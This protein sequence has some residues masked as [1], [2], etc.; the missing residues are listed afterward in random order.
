MSNKLYIDPISA[1]VRE[2]R[3]LFAFAKK[4]NLSFGIF[5][6]LGI[7]TYARCLFEAGILPKSLEDDYFSILSRDKDYL[8]RLLDKR[9]QRVNNQLN[10]STAFKVEVPKPSAPDWSQWEDGEEI[11]VRLYTQKIFTKEER[12][13]WMSRY[14]STR[15]DLGGDGLTEFD[16]FRQEYLNEFQFRM[17]QDPHF[18]FKNIRAGDILHVVSEWAEA[19]YESSKNAVS[20]YSE[21]TGNRLNVA[22]VI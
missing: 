11:K 17:K 15:P 6:R 10:L 13:F 5:L 9:I 3:A 18:P 20:P 4:L 7:I 8:Q 12:V 19:E 16:D 2:E 22:E 14:R 1:A 21:P